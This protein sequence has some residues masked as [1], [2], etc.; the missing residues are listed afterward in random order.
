[1]PVQLWVREKTSWCCENINSQFAVNSLS[2][3]IH[4]LIPQ[5]G[6]H[7]FNLFKELVK[8]IWLNINAFSLFDHFL[9]VRDK[10]RSKT[11]YW[12]CWNFR[13]SKI[14]VFCNMPCFIVF[15]TAVYWSWNGR[16][17]R[18]FTILLG[19]NWCLSLLGLKGFTKSF[20]A[21]VEKAVSVYNKIKQFNWGL[22]RRIIDKSNITLQVKHSKIC[23][24][25]DTLGLQR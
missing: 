6:V 5:N 23:F 13:S 12:Y 14:L 17:I 24:N 19:E 15:V 11:L 20:Y 1:M 7:T 16:G 21:G 3:N 22:T 4:A 2:L 10:L 9:E 8:R 25:N 18:V